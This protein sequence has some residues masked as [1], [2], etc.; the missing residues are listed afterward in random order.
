MVR[1]ARKLPRSG[2]SPS[3]LAAPESGRERRLVA[4]ARAAVKASRADHRRK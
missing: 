2:G 4:K 1:S 3:T